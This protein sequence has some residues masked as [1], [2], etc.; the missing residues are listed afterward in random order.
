LSKFKSYYIAQS[1]LSLSEA[2]KN[3]KHFQEEKH[4]VTNYMIVKGVINR[5]SILPESF[6]INDKTMKPFVEV[7][8]KLL[9]YGDLH[10]S[11]NYII[12]PGKLHDR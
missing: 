5:N 11:P 2:Q 4:L 7:P 6:E 8:L 12:R 10:D 3:T 9:N 1:N